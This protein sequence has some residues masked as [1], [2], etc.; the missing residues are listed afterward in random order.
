MLTT[1]LSCPTPPKKTPLSVG[2]SQGVKEVRHGE[3]P[4]FGGD[5]G[6]HIYL[7]EYNT[8][9]IGFKHKVKEKYRRMVKWLNR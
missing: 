8:E 9:T 3:E 6:Y 7:V 1:S 5:R 4:L 2:T